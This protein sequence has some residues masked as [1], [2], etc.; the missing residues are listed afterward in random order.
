LLRS[1][2]ITALVL[3]PLVIAAI[4]LLPLYGF[5]LA[6]WL[7]AAAGAWEWAGLAGVSGAAGRAVYVAILAGL[8]GAVWTVPDYWTHVLWLGVG[9]W[10]CAA[11]AV[12]S[13]PRGAGLSV[14]PLIALPAGLVAALAAW[15]ALVVVRAEP[16]G[17]TWV[18]W[19]LFLVWAADIGAYFAGRRFGRRKLAPR[20]S[21]G[22]TWEGLAGGVAVSLAVTVAMLWPMGAFTPV[23]IPLIVLLVGVSVFGDLFESVMKRSRGVKDSGSL[24]PGHG[25][26]LDRIDSVIAAL[27][28]FALLLQ[29]GL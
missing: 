19:L 12:L 22:K 16:G 29:R 7:I 15:M 25:G 5:A 18:L 24:L 14:H 6:F 21:P 26:A 23:W 8:A 1:R 2:I 11:L 9:F 27:P 3:A 20:V 13:Y 28:V 17:A 4:Y 10:I